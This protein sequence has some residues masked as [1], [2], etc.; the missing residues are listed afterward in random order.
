MKTVVRSVREEKGQFF[1]GAVVIDV[2]EFVMDVTKSSDVPW[3]QTLSRTSS[4]VSTS[5]ALAWQTT[6]RSAGR[7]S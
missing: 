1:I 4:R 7:T 5:Q 2:A 6:S 3:R